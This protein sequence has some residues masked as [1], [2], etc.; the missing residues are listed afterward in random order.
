MRVRDITVRLRREPLLLF[1]VVGVLLFA[2]HR[3]FSAATGIDN[4]RVIDIDRASVLRFTQ[5]RSKVFDEAGAAQA[6]AAMPAAERKATIDQLAREE[7]LYREAVAWG[8]DRDDYVI[9]RR[10]VQSLEFAVADEGGTPPRLDEAQLRRFYADHPELYRD[11]ATIS[12]THIFFSKDKG[13]IAAADARARAAL[14]GAGSRDGDLSGMGD[15][16]LYFPNYAR[17]GPD[18]IRGHFGEDMAKALFALKPGAAW[19]GPIRSDHG[20]H[21]VRLL[22]RNPGGV[23]PFEAVRALVARD[24][25]L[26]ERK[27]IQ[28]EA[29]ARI[30]GSYRVR[31]AAD[32]ETAR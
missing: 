31:L 8:L 21:L 17:Q 1:L 22:A 30:V 7:A 20:V 3:L 29:I 4:P 14:A 25:A 16:F 26:A 12:F 15:R 11:G 13:G 24:A 19:Q 32:L 27:R 5:F 23:P 28:D 9:R 18:M 2:A 6:W 10:L